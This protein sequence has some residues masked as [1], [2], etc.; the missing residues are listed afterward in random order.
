MAD[1]LS[2]TYQTQDIPEY[3]RPFR[4][5]LL[6]SAFSSVY[7]PEAMKNFLPNAT[8]F[9]AYTQN[10]PNQQQ[11]TSGNTGDTG[12]TGNERN[13]AASNEENNKNA[14]FNALN[15]VSGKMPKLPGLVWDTNTRTYVPEA[16]KTIKSAKGGELNPKEDPIQKILDEYQGLREKMPVGFN[17]AASPAADAKSL[18]GGVTYPE[19]KNPF[20]V[21][22]GPS[23]TSSYTIGDNISPDITRFNPT[24]V[25]NP[26]VVTPVGTGVTTPPGGGG[27]GV[28]TIGG[29]QTGG[30]G[31]RDP[32]LD[33]RVTPS[34][35][36]GT[37]GTP[38]RPPGTP[39]TGVGT[40]GEV[41]SV[42]LL[43]LFL[44]VLLGLLLLIKV[45]VGITHFSMLLTIRLEDL[46]RCLVVP[47]RGRIHLVHLMFP[48][49]I[50]LA[51]VAVTRSMLA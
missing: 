12:T 15:M 50:R 7:T 26:R 1:P 5:A 11:N 2:S 40:G 22:R 4:N 23:Q 28:G 24:P 30:P 39:G 17:Q 16:Y 48:H 51:L 19:F 8:Y 29:P 42:I 32:S 36:P 27:G 44:V 47:T 49:R 10:Q 9:N 14:I 35:P 31:P 45:L 6:S 34:T 46:P 33:R 3:L 18:T 38:A 21:T 37:P 13:D 41:V 25:I 20:N 43:R